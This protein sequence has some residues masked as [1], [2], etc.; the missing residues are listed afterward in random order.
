M[1]EVLSIVL[2]PPISNA[3]LA[4]L[5]AMKAKYPTALACPNPPAQTALWVRSSKNITK[6]TLSLP[7]KMLALK[8]N[9]PNN[10][11]LKRSFSNKPKFTLKRLLPK[12]N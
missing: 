5:L 2:A 1:E 12:K 9:S 10:P 8:R 11:L 6:E 7:R 3:P 4:A